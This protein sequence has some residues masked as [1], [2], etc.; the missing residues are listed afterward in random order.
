MSTCSFDTKVCPQETI[1]TTGVVITWPQTNPGQITITQCPSTA[2]SA[3]RNCSVN[4]TWGE[5]FVCDCLSSSVAQMLC[6]SNVRDSA[7][8]H[9][10]D[11]VYNHIYMYSI[12]TYI[13]IYIYIY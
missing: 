1:T 8:M 10:L 5:P 2:G 6:G 12:Y 3:M 11:G 7:C 9:E 4:A 13:Y